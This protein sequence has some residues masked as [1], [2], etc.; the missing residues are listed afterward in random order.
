MR[1]RFGATLVLS[2]G[3]RTAYRLVLG[4]SWLVIVAALCWTF[5]LAVFLGSLSKA[6]WPILLSRIIGT[7]AFIGMPIAAAWNLTLARKR[8]APWLAELSSALLFAAAL[9][10]LWVTF[11]FHLIGFSTRF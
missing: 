6:D 10:I 5:V 8:K 9:V 2:G 3:D 11:D 7:I 1:R 4:F